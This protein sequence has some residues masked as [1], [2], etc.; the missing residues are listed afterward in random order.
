[1]NILG[2]SF[3]HNLH[4]YLTVF[5]LTSVLCVQSGTTF[6]NKSQNNTRFPF[7]R[8]LLTSYDQIS[9]TI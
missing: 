5:K 2:H 8:V 3:C 9:I 7:Y 6:S 1:M 4:V